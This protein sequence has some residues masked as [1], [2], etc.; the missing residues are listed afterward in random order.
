MKLRNF[1]IN[2]TKFIDKL[3]QSNNC[4]LIRKRK[5]SF[6]VQSQLPPKSHKWAVLPR[7]WTFS[8]FSKLASTSSSRIS[9]TKKCSSYRLSRRIKSSGKIW[10]KKSQ[11]GFWTSYSEKVPVTRRAFS[12]WISFSQNSCKICKTYSSWRPCR[13]NNWMIRRRLVSFK[14]MS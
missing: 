12:L 11:R 7:D 14:W 9:K 1:T 13:S 6:T 4:K 5:T 10:G 3:N 8:R 2:T